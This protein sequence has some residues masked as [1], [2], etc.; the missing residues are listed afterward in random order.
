MKLILL[1]LSGSL[2]ITSKTDIKKT[3][4]ETD[5]LF[6]NKNWQLDE[7]RFL[8]DNVPYYYKRG[9]NTNSNM[10]FDND[11]ITFFDSGKGVYHQGDGEEYSLEWIQN[12]KTDLIYTIK[13][14]R[15]NKDL[16]VTWEH[17]KYEG[18]TISYTEFYTHRNGIHSLGYGILSCNCPTQ[19]VHDD[20][21]KIKSETNIVNINH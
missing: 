14:F 18:D 1:L 6:V 20:N 16:V 2:F 5:L 21:L 17:F 8:Q 7:I 15:F 9:D 13:K 12:E 11:F 3:P 4:S 10:N 19:Y